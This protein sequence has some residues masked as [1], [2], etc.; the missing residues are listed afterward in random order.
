MITLLIHCKSDEGGQV[1]LVHMRF[2]SMYTMFRRALYTR[3]YPD[4][5][6][7]VLY[8]FL[9]LFG[10]QES[11]FKLSDSSHDRD[12]IYES[13][14]FFLFLVIS[15]GSLTSTIDYHN[16]QND[17]DKQNDHDKLCL[18]LSMRAIFFQ[19]QILFTHFL[20]HHI[21]IADIALTFL[22]SLFMFQSIFVFYNPHTHFPL[23]LS[24]SLSDLYSFIV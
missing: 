16:K 7:T 18:L 14:V 2:V 3:I 11:V 22:L 6:H 1:I 17:N 4:R 21:Q 19:V 13:N 23:L 24:C 9:L 12:L 8:F 10:Q 20:L 5:H 15:H